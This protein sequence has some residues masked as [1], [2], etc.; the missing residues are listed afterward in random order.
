MRKKEFMKKSEARIIVYLDQVENKVKTGRYLSETL[1]ID[2][3]YIMKLL[4][5]MY[6][7]GWIKS[8]KYQ[9]R[10]YFELTVNTPRRIAN[11][12][13]TNEQTTIE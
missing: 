3:I 12:T 7:K 11:E 13:I 1:K 6:N 2:Y 4:R 10:S 5:E 9:E 8:H